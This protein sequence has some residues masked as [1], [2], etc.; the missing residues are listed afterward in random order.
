MACVFVHGTRICAVSNGYFLDITHTSRCYVTRVSWYPKPH[1]MTN[2]PVYWTP[3]IPPTQFLEPERG[4]SPILHSFLHLHAT[5]PSIYHSFFATVATV[6]SIH[7][8]FLW[9]HT[10]DSSIMT[11]CCYC[12]PLAILR[13]Y[14]SNLHAQGFGDTRIP[15]VFRFLTI[16]IIIPCFFLWY[17]YVYISIRLLTILTWRKTLQL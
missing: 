3:L 15:R 16:C 1:K 11:V 5:D 2:V 13:L 6:P 8:C 7:H 10:T 12:T 14:L 4:W 17:T 9:L